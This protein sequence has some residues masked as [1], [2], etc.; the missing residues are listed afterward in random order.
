[1]DHISEYTDPR[2]PNCNQTEEALA[3]L[4]DNIPMGVLRKLIDNIPAHAHI[5][6]ELIR[7]K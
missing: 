3:E 5:Y 2:C 1:M 6:R 7:K 4:I